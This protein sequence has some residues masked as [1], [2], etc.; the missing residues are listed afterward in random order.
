MAHPPPPTLRWACGPLGRFLR[1][2][3]APRLEFRDL[4]PCS[5]AV[6]GYPSPPPSP[7]PPPPAWPRSRDSLPMRAER[8][9]IALFNSGPWAPL[10]PSSPPRTLPHPALTHGLLCWGPIALADKCGDSLPYSSLATPRP[11]P[12]PAFVFFFPPLSPSP[13]SS[14]LCLAALFLL[15]FT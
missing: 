6:H 8:G 1:G 2:L 15:T 5:P 12:F 4:L 9:L 11:P 13:S 10:Q 3:T 14:P 7:S